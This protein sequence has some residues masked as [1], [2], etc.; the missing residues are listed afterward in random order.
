MQIDEADLADHGIVDHVVE[1][2]IAVD[3]DGKGSGQRRLAGPRPFDQ[4]TKAGQL[5]AIDNLR[6]RLVACDTPVKPDTA[7]R[8]DTNCSQNIDEAKALLAEAGYN[9]E[10]LILNISD[11]CPDWTPLAEVYQQQAALAGINLEI[12][13]HPSDGYWTDAWMVE[14]LTATC[15][16]ESPADQI[17]NT[18]FRTGT[19]WNETFWN[20]SNFDALLDTARS[21]LDFKTRQAIYQEA[22]QLIWEDGGAMIPYHKQ[23]YRATTQCVLNVPAVGLFQVNW[24]DVGIT[25]G[26]GG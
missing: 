13:I 7:Y 23:G 24:A 6:T 20:N 22:Q 9:G 4:R 12:E 17:L 1:I 3:V 16:P 15:W 2:E 11:F 21:E 26:C 10:P 8:F 19:P 5:S 25:P 14:P 18:A